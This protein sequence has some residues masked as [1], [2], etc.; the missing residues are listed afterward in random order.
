MNRRKE[1]TEMERKQEIIRRIMQDSIDY[2]LVIFKNEYKLIKDEDV[3]FEVEDDSVNK[4]ALKNKLD[5]MDDNLFV[6][7][8]IVKDSSSVITIRAVFNSS[9]IQKSELSFFRIENFY[10]LCGTL[11]EI[12]KSVNDIEMGM[13]VVIPP[14]ILIKNLM[15]YPLQMILYSFFPKLQST[16]THPEYQRLLGVSTNT[17]KMVI[18]NMT[19]LGPLP[20][21]FQYSNASIRN[22]CQRFD[23]IPED[24]VL[25]L[26]CNIECRNGER[27]HRVTRRWNKV[28]ATT[29]NFEQLLGT[30]DVKVLLRIQINDVDR[31]TFCDPADIAYTHVA[32][33][34]QKF[35][36]TLSF[37]LGPS[38][39]EEYTLPFCSEQHFRQM[40]MTPTPLVNVNKLNLSFI[41]IHLRSFMEYMLT[42]RDLTELRLHDVILSDDDETDIEDFYVRLENAMKNVHTFEVRRL[43]TV[44]E[45]RDL[46]L[47]ENNRFW[48]VLSKLPKLKSLYLREFFLPDPSAYPEEYQHD[49]DFDEDDDDD[50]DGDDNFMPFSL[51]EIGTGLSSLTQLTFLSLSFCQY[52]PKSI[53]ELLHPVIIKLEKLVSLDLSNTGLKENMINAFIPT[54]IGLPNLSILNV[55]NNPLLN[56]NDIKYLTEILGKKVRIIK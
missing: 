48:K 15:K 33:I 10:V 21:D 27:R 35:P 38:N 34:T 41:R 40:M 52:T 46:Q 16:L 11:T 2:I 25:R 43:F 20:D 6:V 14:K 45:R 19:V 50:Y 28:C 32:N 4:L 17:K 18:E 29:P 51:G 54:L 13:I 47:V 8:Q 9:D 55:S 12:F 36:N 23:K 39:L 24:C 53:I 42:L 31:H 1:E 56:G 49:D 7:C 3:T 44:G 37:E 5:I 22:E 30:S 26:N